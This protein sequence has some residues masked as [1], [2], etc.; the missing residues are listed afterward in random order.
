MRIV[1]VSLPTPHDVQAFVGKISPLDG[2]FDLLANGYVLDAKSLMGIFGLDL[3]KPLKL[4]IEK[5]TKETMQAVKR[6][7]V[8]E[9]LSL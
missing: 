9:K 4:R 7:L 8:E 3:T 6:F 1:Y 5:D 2:Q